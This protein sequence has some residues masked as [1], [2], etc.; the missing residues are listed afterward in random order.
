M[1]TLFQERPECYKTEQNSKV[2]G[3]VEVPACVHKVMN[4]I[5]SLMPIL[6]CFGL[7][8][9]KF[10]SKLC[11]EQHFPQMSKRLCC[12]CAASLEGKW[13]YWHGVHHLCEEC[14]AHHHPIACDW[15]KKWNKKT[16]ADYD[17]WFHRWLFWGDRCCITHPELDP[18]TGLLR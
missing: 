17:H 1:Q 10:K 18:A 4:G 14:H 12:S 9:L 16:Q 11:V 15:C 7:P 6:I 5:V 3:T 8:A 2:L 13:E